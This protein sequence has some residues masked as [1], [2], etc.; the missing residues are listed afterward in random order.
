MKLPK[1][2]ELYPMVER[3]VKRHFRCF[4][5]ATNRGLAYSR[6]DVVGV[7]DI[8]GDLSGDV[9]T[10][11]V[12]V[13]RRTR[14]FATACGQ[15]L[16]YKVYANRVYLAIFRKEPYT[17]EELAIASH[18]GIGLVRIWGNRCHEVLSSPY[19]DP[20]PRLGLSVMEKLRLCKCQL[21]GCFFEIG[22]VSGNR[23]ANLARQGV[24]K[25][26]RDEKGILFWNMEV[27]NRKKSLGLR[28]APDG[29]S[30]ERRFICPDCVYSFFSEFV[31]EPDQ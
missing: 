27:A 9:E 23:W 15:T 11:V 12:E 6:M 28:Q 25:A 5:T 1:E 14:T 30:F 31:E 17:P 24:S 16:G 29:T 2:E 22:D 18:L 3:W 13:K 21:C 19:Y 10:I 26:L 4:K 20:M 8:G 7:R